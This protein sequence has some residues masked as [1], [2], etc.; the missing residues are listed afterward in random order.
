MRALPT[1]DRAAIDPEPVRDDVHGD[2]AFEHLDRPQPPAFEFSGAPLWAHRH[3]PQR[4]IG[5]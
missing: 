2:V 4:S 3:L 5:H 1:P